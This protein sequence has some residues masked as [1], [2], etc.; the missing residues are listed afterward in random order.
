MFCP[1]CGTALDEGALLCRQC[2][3]HLDETFYPQA[4]KVQHS[5]LWWFVVIMIGLVV[6]SM[7]M[8]ALLYLMVMAV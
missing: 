7:L 6:V 5:M 8:T 4:G 1:R 2:G 3:F